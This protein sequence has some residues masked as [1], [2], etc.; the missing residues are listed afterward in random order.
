VDVRRGTGLVTLV[1]H[2]EQDRKERSYA[3]EIR[4]ARG[5]PV[6]RGSGL[7][8][9]TFDTFTLGLPRTLVPAGAYEIRLLAEDGGP[10]TLVDTYRISL[11]YR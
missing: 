2:L 8:K 6:W 4:D 3:V 5:H 11:R 7:V 1:L 10:S 9:S